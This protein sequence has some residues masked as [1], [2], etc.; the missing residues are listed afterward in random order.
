MDVTLDELNGTEAELLEQIQAM[1]IHDK[2]KIRLVNR[3]RNCFRLYRA[4]LWLEQQVEKR[5]K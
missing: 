3:T 2:L 5:R 1:D 4:M